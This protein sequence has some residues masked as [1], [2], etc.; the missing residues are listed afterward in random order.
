LTAVHGTEDPTLL[1]GTSRPGTSPET[2]ICFNCHG[3]AAVGA[4]RSNSDLYTETSK[5]VRH[6]ANDTVHDTLDED[7][8]TFADGSFA[9]AKRHA[10]CL[11]CH[12]PHRAGAAI[13]PYPTSGT[14]DGTRNQIVADGT[15]VGAAGVTYTPNEYVTGTITVAAGGAVSASGGA[16]FDP[17]M[18]GGRIWIGGTTATANG[19]GS[20]I[21]SGYTSPTQLTVTPAPAAGTGLL[22]RIVK[23]SSAE[24]FSTTPTALGNSSGEYQLCF[25]CHSAFAFNTAYGKP[26]GTTYVAGTAAFTAGSVM[27]TGTGTT[28]T[29][30]HVGWAIKNN[31]D[32]T[33]YRV[34]SFVSATSLV[35]DRPP[36]AGM[37]GAY[38]LQQSY[39]DVS[40]EFSPSN[41][42]GHPVYT[43]LAN[44]TGSKAPRALAPGQMK[45]PWTNVGNQ[46][47]ACTDCHTGDG[48][49]SPVVQGPHGSAV[50]L[51]LKGAN[52]ANW[53]TPTIP[54]G[55]A[56]SW[57]ANCHIS[58]SGHPHSEGDHGGYQCYRCHIVV[59]H[60]GKLARL[61]VDLDSPNM[62][63]RYAYQGNKGGYTGNTG[64]NKKATPNSY[65]ESDC[66]TNCGEHSRTSGEDW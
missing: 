30:I 24:S 10:N 66:G 41:A 21:I 43:S 44:Y 38:T 33:W 65:S 29:T 1:A 22:Y 53:P 37:S 48:A 45:A 36:P 42:S 8:A 55:Y 49:T 2:F 15:L 6:A 4:T 20:F 51:M 58:V 61:I 50:R 54:G 19:Q 60:G 63:S 23:N 9:G 40:D 14:M 17:S 3:S 16:T 26:G 62:P 13:R 12:D 35:I 31:A 5:T 27:V 39:L 64:F 34:M 25:K 52:A 18:L 57:C 7:R 11:D 32:G 59:P 46:T 47:M 28:W 56:T